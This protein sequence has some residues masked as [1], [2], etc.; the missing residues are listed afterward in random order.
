MMVERGSRKSSVCT[1]RARVGGRC[2]EIA[3]NASFNGR[4]VAIDGW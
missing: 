1:E 3:A 2:G 4:G